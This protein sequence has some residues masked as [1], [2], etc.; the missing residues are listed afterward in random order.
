[1]ILVVGST[2]TVGGMVARRLLAEGRNVRVLVRPASNYQPLVE[3]GA[4][5]VFGD[6]KDPASLK[7]AC[8]GVDT[9]ITTANSAMRGGDDN[10][11]TVEH[12]GNINLIDAAAEAGIKQFIF[13]SASNASAES[14]APF[15][16]GK[17][18]AEQHLVASGLPYTIIAPGPFTEVW[19]GMIAA[20]P[21]GQGLPVTIY[22]H[23]RQAF[24]PMKDVL[25]FILAV[26]DHPAALNQRLVIAGMQP[27]SFAEAG[28]AIGKIIGCEVG[29]VQVNMGDPV[30]TLPPPLIPMMIGM[31]LSDW[32]VPMDELSRTYNV[33]MT[34]M[35]ESLR[36]MLT[37]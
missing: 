36:E 32:S 26:V 15:L 3:A 2:G 19:V 12:Q 6:L 20:A 29:V 33:Q 21:V 25:A 23:A 34:S 28:A 13:V 24:I 11:M 1:M 31:S 37:R 10:P 14:P 9:V 7:A 17:G 5:P 18:K 30:P 16:A 8:Q 27:Y 35:E 22:S 4:Q